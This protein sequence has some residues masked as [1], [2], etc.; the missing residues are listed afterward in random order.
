MVEG[1]TV[2]EEAARWQ[3]A[4]GG[5]EVAASRV[6]LA[7]RRRFG[8]GVVGWASVTALIWG[9]GRAAS[10]RRAHGTTAARG[11]PCYPCAPPL[12]PALCA[13][14]EQHAVA[15]NLDPARE[16]AA[17]GRGDGGRRRGRRGG[18][19]AV[20]R[21]RAEK[22]RRQGEE[23]EGGRGCR[24]MVR[25]RGLGF[26]VAGGGKWKLLCGGA[27]ANVIV[28]LFFSSSCPNKHSCEVVCG[29]Y[30]NVATV[31]SGRSGFSC[32]F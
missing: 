19:A 27:F 11:A 23:R 15:P 6:G 10:W 7:S 8:R 30:K 5:E 14:I 24:E 16:R 12:M 29:K 20:G 28:L 18:E 22:G 3:E 4:R 21:Q 32:D 9:G 1:F 17:T 31:R 13:S 2:K 26:G 25:D